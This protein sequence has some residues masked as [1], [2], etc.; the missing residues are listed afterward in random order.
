M[1]LW[2][3]LILM[4]VVVGFVLLMYAAMRGSEDSNDG[5]F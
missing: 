3:G 4:C 5:Y 1:E 2:E